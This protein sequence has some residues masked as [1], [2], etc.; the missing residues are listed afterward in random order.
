MQ[1][2]NSRAGVVHWIDHYVL[3]TTDVE[4]YTKFHCELLGAEVFPDPRGFLRDIG[5]FLTFG[6]MRVGGFDNKAPLPPTLGLRKGLPRYGLYIDAADIDRHLRRLDAVG[7]IHSQPERVTNEG[8]AGTTIY[9]QDPDGNQFEF[10]APDVLPEGALAGCGPERVGLISH[11]VFE[12]RDLERTATFFERYCAAE[13]IVATRPDTLALR[14][15]G[16]ARIIYHKVDTLGGRTTGM[17][18]R[19]THTALLVRSEDFVPNYQRLWAE[20]PEWDYNPIERKPIENP[21]ALPARTVLHPT[22]GGKRCKEITGRGDDF[23][24]WDTNMFHFFGGTPVGDSLAVYE[25]L[26]TEDYLTEFEQLSA[27]V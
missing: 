22:P 16:G 1:N 2:D 4:R 12:S 8:E 3:C 23:L 24:D 25:G 6:R 11:A 13:R 18:L 9:W 26:S 5:V 17:G 27:P 7:A 15:A 19:D 21:G 14:L 20:L 10:W